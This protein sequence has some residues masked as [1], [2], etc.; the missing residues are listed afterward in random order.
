MTQIELLKAEI[1]RLKKENN[2]RESSSYV[3]GM[4]REAK[5]IIERTKL[6]GIWH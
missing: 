5:K 4:L 2:S 1:E 3:K 6:V